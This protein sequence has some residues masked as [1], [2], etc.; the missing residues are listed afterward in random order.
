MSADETSGLSSITGVHTVVV[1]VV[2]MDQALTFWTGALGFE[3]QMDSP[4]GE[5]Q[6]W[7]ELAARDAGAGATTIGLMSG[8]GQ[9][10]GV[11]TGIRLATSDA[12]AAWRVLEEAGVDVDE[13]LTLPGAPP[14]F[15]FR[16]GDGNELVV[17]EIDA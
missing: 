13:L 3:V 8:G 17:V 1:P 6:R 11:N 9:P 2:D 14:M 16:D 4:F 15:T 5:G 7:V 12:A 10:T